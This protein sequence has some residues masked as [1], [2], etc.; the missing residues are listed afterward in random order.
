MAVRSTRAA[1]FLAG[2]LFALFL[3][4]APFTAV[5]AGGYDDDRYQESDR[6]YHGEQPYRYERRSETRALRDE[7]EP[8]VFATTRMVNDWDVPAAMK[9]PLF[10]PAV[11]IDLV[12]LPAELVA[13]AVR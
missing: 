10:P 11:I 9:V 1:R 2:C 6:G 13:D 4:S 3:A 8:Y 12:F 5:Y 7:D